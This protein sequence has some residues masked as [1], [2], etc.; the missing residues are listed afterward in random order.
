MSTP[1]PRRLS[2]VPPALPGTADRAPD[3]AV[4]PAAAWLAGHGPELVALRRDVHAHPELGRQE[5]RTTGLL[6]ERLRAAGL[7]PRLLPGTGLTCDIGDP[8]AGPTVLLRADIDALPLPDECGHPWTS[9]VPSVAH[10]CGHDVHTSCVLGAGLAL[11]ELH[12]RS[13]LPGRVRLLFQPAEEV[14]PGGALD[15]IRAGVLD[16]VD[17]ALALHC[18]PRLE[19]GHIGVRVGPMTAAADQ[20]EV[21]LAGPGGHTSRPQLTCDLVYALGCVVTQVPAMLSR[22]VDPRSALSLVW[23]HV[24]AGSVPNAIPRLGR[25]AGTVRVLDREAWVSAPALIERCV[26]AVAEPLGAG[27]EIEYRRGVPPV[28]NEAV[29]TRLLSDAADAVLGPEAAVPTGQSLGGEDFSWYLDAVDGAMAR[30]GTRGPDMP[31]LDL[32]QPRFDVDERAIDIGVRVLARAALDGLA[33]PL[34]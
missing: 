9:T 28:V 8:S 33:A 7:A 17:R 19:L 27:V 32:H 10:A 22:L 12:A 18:D 6:A 5:H 34:H 11:A 24:S 25:A 13:P 23:G 3:P 4:D 16:G 20:V 31:L 26:R 29:C 30:L 14:M 2:A 15:S 1:G 21:R